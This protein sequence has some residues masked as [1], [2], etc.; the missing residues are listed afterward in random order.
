MHQRLNKGD[1]LRLTGGLVMSSPFHTEILGCPFEAVF[2]ICAIWSILLFNLIEDYQEIGIGLMIGLSL[3]TAWLWGKYGCMVLVF[4][5]GMFCLWMC[6][7]FIFVHGKDIWNRVPE[8]LARF[9]V[10]FV[11]LLIFFSIIFLILGGGYYFLSEELRGR[12]V[13]WLL[14]GL[15]VICILGVFGIFVWLVIDKSQKGGGS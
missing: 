2:V 13:D 10:K 12:I 1:K 5:G 6:I 4:G 7:G 15:G 14:I 9:I 11:N 3:L 8:P